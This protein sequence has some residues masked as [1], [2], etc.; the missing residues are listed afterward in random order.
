MQSASG[1]GLMGRGSPV[2]SGQMTFKM[3]G[4]EMTMSGSGGGMM[5]STFHRIMNGAKNILVS[6]Y[7]EGNRFLPNRITHPEEDRAGAFRKE[8]RSAPDSATWEG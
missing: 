7:S 5:T 6:I 8:I 3:S 4:G 2:S 1:Y